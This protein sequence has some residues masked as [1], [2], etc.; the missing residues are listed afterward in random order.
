MPTTLDRSVSRLVAL[1][2]AAAVTVAT[3]VGLDGLARQDY[4]AQLA[5]AAVSATRG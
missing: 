3:L 5:K 1:A 2:L 4:R